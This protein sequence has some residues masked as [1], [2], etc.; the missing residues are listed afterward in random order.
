MAIGRVFNGKKYILAS[1]HDYKADA[2]SRARYWR[3]HGYL[4][5]VTR[6]TGRYK[7]TSTY[8]VWKRAKRSSK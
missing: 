8:F 6:G 4:S 5:R 1:P 2:N 7:G 3:A